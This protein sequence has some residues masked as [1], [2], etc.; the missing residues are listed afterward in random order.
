MFVKGLKPNYF[1]NSKYL[2]YCS[3]YWLP[4]PFFWLFNGSPDKIFLSEE[5]IFGYRAGS[6]FKML[7]VF[8]KNSRVLINQKVVMPIPTSP[9]FKAQIGT[10]NPVF[11]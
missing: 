4:A 11:V 3:G 2:T 7:I 9:I 8:G 10:I 6:H 5:N 1:N